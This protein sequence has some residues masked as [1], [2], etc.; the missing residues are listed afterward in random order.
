MP[1]RFVETT[2]A[3]Q[4]FNPRAA[5]RRWCRIRRLLWHAQCVGRDHWR[6]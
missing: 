3:R 6:L 2:M 1:S 5:G 4:V